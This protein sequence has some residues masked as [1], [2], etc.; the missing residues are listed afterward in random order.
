[1]VNIGL[2][3]CSS[4][5]DR[6]G[7]WMSWHMGGLS[8]R[9]SRKAKGWGWGWEPEVTD[10][11]MWPVQPWVRLL[12]PLLWFSKEIL[13]LSHLKWCYPY[14]VA[15]P[16]TQLGSNYWKGKGSVEQ[17]FVHWKIMSGELLE[18]SRDLKTLALVTFFFFLQCFVL[19]CL[20]LWT[21]S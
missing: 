14:K 7:S 18:C 8:T 19:F 10:A 17:V 9:H 5:R 20:V 21:W 1:M 4:C 15:L 2:V 16:A 13:G 12:T 3:H 6:T 11:N